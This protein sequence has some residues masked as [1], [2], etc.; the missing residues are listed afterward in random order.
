MRRIKVVTKNLYLW[1][2][3][4]L[5]LADNAITELGGSFS[6]SDDLCFWDIDSMGTPPFSEKILTVG[7]S[8]EAA[9][10]LPLSFETIRKNAL[11]AEGSAPLQLNGRICSFK[12]EKIKLTEL[13]ATLLSILIKAEGEFVS[14]EEILDKVWQNKADVGIINVYIHYLREKLEKGEKVI[15]SSRKQGYKIDEKFLE[16]VNN[17]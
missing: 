12:G 5:L 6:E 14:R 3:I 9:F 7:K 10:T 8:G 15:L 16:D 11:R 17:A 4:R 1:Q 2:K 13:E